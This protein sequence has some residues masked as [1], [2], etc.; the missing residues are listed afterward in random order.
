MHTHFWRELP[1][2]IYPRFLVLKSA[3]KVADFTFLFGCP[4]KISPAGLQFFWPVHQYQPVRYLERVQVLL[5]STY[6][7]LRS[8]R[9]RELVKSMKIVFHRWI[10]ENFNFDIFSES[11]EYLWSWIHASNITRN[12]TLERLFECF[13][14]NLSFLG[15]TKVHED[16]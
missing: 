12:I 8:C 13:Y 5:M 15:W 3:V 16:P 14:Q 10:S 6:A 7:I 1:N 2:M 9:R 11:N 4:F